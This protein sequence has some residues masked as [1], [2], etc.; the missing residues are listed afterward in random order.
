LFAIKTDRRK[1]TASEKDDEELPSNGHEI[2][3]Q[4]VPVLQDP[5]K[6]IEAVIKTTV[7]EWTVSPRS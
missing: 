5:F 4:K 3:P 7:T 6:D 2:D 1:S